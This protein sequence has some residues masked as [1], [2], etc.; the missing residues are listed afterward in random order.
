MQDIDGQL[1]S[2]KF[3]TFAKAMIAVKKLEDSTK[4]LTKLVITLPEKPFMKW[5]LDFISSIKPT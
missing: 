1:Y 2:K 4:S 3:M 5:G